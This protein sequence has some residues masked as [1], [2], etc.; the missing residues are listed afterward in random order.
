MI[1][2]KNLFFIFLLT[3]WLAVAHG[4]RYEPNTSGLVHDGS[5]DRPES[6]AVTSLE[7]GGQMIYYTPRTTD[8]SFSIIN[9]VPL[10][11]YNQ[12]QA[13]VFK[14]AY[15]IK[16]FAPLDC[17]RADIN[18]SLEPSSPAPI[19]KLIKQSSPLITI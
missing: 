3:P 14:K 15:L 9:E 12:R 7:I 11:C 5:T 13:H 6:S 2:L 10:D 4:D 18:I 19:L 1:K 8:G 17:R 16:S